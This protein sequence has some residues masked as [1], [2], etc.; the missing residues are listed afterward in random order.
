MI[1]SGIE[2]SIVS[3]TDRHLRTTLTGVVEVYFTKAASDHQKLMGFKLFQKAM[4]DGAN[5]D[6]VLPGIFSKNLMACL[7][8][9]ASNP[10]PRLH[11]A[12]IQC[13]KTVDKVVKEHPVLLVPVLQQLL[14]V[15]GCFNLD[16]RL[17]SSEDGIKPVEG[18]LRS[19]DAENGKDVV[20][21]LKAAALDASAE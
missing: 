1:Y 2:S 9:Q 21:A 17:R 7:I 18:L 15:N 20:A 3:C 16:E 6:L 10:G 4:N 8:N 13:L 5:K 12:A 11:R 19:A 14:G